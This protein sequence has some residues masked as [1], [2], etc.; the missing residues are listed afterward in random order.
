MF[1]WEKEGEL[2]NGEKDNERQRAKNAT[3]NERHKDE[4]AR[5]NKEFYA[6]NAD[7]WTKWQKE[8]PDKVKERSLRQNQ[9]EKRKE[10]MREYMKEY[11]KSK[12][13]SAKK[14]E[15]AESGENNT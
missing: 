9:T 1:P 10:Y 12:N 15:S 13:N 14:G 4:R 7:Y 6:D 5:R 11:R 3:W 8:N 2:M